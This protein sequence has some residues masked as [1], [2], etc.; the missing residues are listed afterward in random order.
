MGNIY[1]GMCE[2]LIRMGSSGGVYVPQDKGIG[3]LSSPYGG[4]NVLTAQ[5]SPYLYPPY[6][7]AAV[8]A[9]PTSGGSNQ[10]PKG[11]PID[12]WQGQRF[13]SSHAGGFNMA[14]WRRL[15]PFDH[16]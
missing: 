1:Q 4:S 11:V 9:T 3:V 8:W 16:L 12:N 2:G 15:G 7:D 10:A 14:F 5:Y 6:Q 13:G